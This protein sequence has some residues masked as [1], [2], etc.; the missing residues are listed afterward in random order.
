MNLAR[1]ALAVTTT[2]VLA[3]ACGGEDKDSKKNDKTE[4]AAGNE[5]QAGTK[6]N[7]Q[8]PTTTQSAE[9]DGITGLFGQ[10][11]KNPNLLEDVLK[12]F[13]SLLGQGG[14]ASGLEGL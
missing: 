13:S 9:T 4:T 5:D 2:V 10:I 14:E 8:P 1:Q 3:A 12:L 7:C 6:N 11:L